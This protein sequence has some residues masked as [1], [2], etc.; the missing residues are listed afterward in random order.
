MFWID[1]TTIICY[2]FFKGL[3]ETLI[4]DTPD[5][6]PHKPILFWLVVALLDTTAW[7]FYSFD[8]THTHAIVEELLELPDAV[9]LVVFFCV[10]LLLV[11]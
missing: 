3:E 4:A 6:L 11:S 10:M 2:T 7:D 1:I 5:P 9:V 8:G